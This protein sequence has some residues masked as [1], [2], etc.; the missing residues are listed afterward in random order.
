MPKI[1]QCAI[2]RKSFLGTTYTLIDIIN[3][4]TTKR[5]IHNLLQITVSRL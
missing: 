3:V 1:V 4:Y 2:C 5:R